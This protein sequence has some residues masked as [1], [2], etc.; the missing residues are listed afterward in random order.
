MTWYSSVS[1]MSKSSASNRYTYWAT[2]LL[3]ERA[4]TLAST[5]ILVI[6]FLA[7]AM[8]SGKVEKI[9]R[10]NETLSGNL[11]STAPRRQR[12][13]LRGCLRRL[14]ACGGVHVEREVALG[15][16]GHF[17]LEWRGR[18]GRFLDRLPGPRAAGLGDLLE[19][20]TGT[21]V[22]AERAFASGN[23]G[24]ITHSEGGARSG[25][26][27]GSEDPPLAWRM[28]GHGREA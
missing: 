18:H 19:P 13:H 26:P 3:S 22:R 14:P 9:Q 25:V 27:Q 15:R 12:K 23:A 4:S 7:R 11:A 5:P 1:L 16:I 28:H 24:G 17:V 10:D 8:V 21:D 6:A 20:L 2:P